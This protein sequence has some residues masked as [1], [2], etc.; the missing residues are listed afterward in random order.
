MIPVQTQ[1]KIIDNFLDEQTFNNIQS[2]MFSPDFPWHYNETSTTPPAPSVS[3]FT[4]AFYWHNIA[5]NSY[6]LINPLVVKIKPKSLQRVKAN[7]NVKTDVIIET[8]E[9]TD[10]DDERFLSEF[11]LKEPEV[12]V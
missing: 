6:N 11:K 3:Q 12:L 5:R 10:L 1:I 8:G 7:L 2:A 9:H 4:H